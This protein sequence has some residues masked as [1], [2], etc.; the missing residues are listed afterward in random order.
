MR[1]DAQRGQK[2]EQK[3]RA[4]R[5]GGGEAEH[6]QVDAHADEDGFAGLAQES[7]QALAQDLRQRGAERSRRCNA[8]SRLSASSCATSRPR[9]APIA[10]RMAI[11][12]SRTLAARQQQI[13]QVRAGNQ[14]HQAGG[15]QQQPER[16]LV[17]AAQAGDA[18]RPAGD[19]S[20]YSRGT[21]WRRRAGR[22]RA[23]TP[24]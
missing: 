14:Q 11:S 1:V 20:A 24:R 13:R 3:T 12:R 9:E 4:H 8:S 21:A 18:G 7:D 10:S 19:A 17:V 22:T 16:L 6:A 15:R 5:H 23:A 2:A